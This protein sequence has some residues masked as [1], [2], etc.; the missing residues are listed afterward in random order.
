MAVQGDHRLRYR[1]IFRRMEK[2][3]AEKGINLS[4]RAISASIKKGRNV[5][6]LEAYEMMRAVMDYERITDRKKAMV[7][8]RK[9]NDGGKRDAIKQA[10]GVVDKVEASLA[11]GHRR[12]SSYPDNRN[13]KKR[14]AMSES[15]TRLYRLQDVIGRRRAQGIHAKKAQ[16]RSEVKGIIPMSRS[17][18]YAGIKEGRYPKPVQLS[19]RS[20]AW[21]SEDIDALLERISQGDWQSVV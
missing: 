3:Y 8:L 9:L 6:R 18:W 7:L 20:V 19:A 4:A 21:R 17:S 16:R 10:L 14:A 15:P 11:A 13:S 5:E 2:D 1:G 12:I